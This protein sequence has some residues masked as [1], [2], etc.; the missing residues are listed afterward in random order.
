MS[1]VRRS[2]VSASMTYAAAELRLMVRVQHNLLLFS[3]FSL[4]EA[5]GSGILAADIILFIKVG[6]KPVGNGRSAFGTAG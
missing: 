4:S 6:N 1:A 2:T 5:S 3:Y